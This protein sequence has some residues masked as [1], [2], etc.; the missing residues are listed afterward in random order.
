MKSAAEHLRTDE[1]SRLA[2]DE[3]ARTAG[4]STDE[5][6]ELID[7]GLLQAQPLDLRTALAVRQAHRL[8]KDFDLDLFTTGLLAGYLRRIDELQAQVR[9]LSAERPARTVYTE[10]SFTSVSVRKA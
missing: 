6:R 1:P 2:L 3:F 4:L 7:Y 8:A 5:V 10:V 9:Q